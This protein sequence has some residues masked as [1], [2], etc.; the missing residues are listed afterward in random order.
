MNL[1]VFP[2]VPVVNSYLIC[3]CLAR[4]IGTSKIGTE[5]RLK[6]ITNM[7]TKL[8]FCSTERLRFTPAL[9]ILNL[10]NNESSLIKS[11]TVFDSLFIS[12]SKIL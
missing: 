2:V 8:N 7:M 12:L 6:Y 11:Y 10:I 5:K 4:I 9:T 3:D 1:I